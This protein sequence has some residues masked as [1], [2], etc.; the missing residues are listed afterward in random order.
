MNITIITPTI[1]SPYLKTLLESIN[2]QHKLNDLFFINHFIVIDNSPINQLKTNSILNSVS[3]KSGVKRYI[4]QIPFSS[5]ENDYKGHKIY[6]AIPQFVNDEYTIFLDDDNFLE[7]NHIYNFV[8]ILLKK[9]YDWLYSLRNIVNSKNEFICNDFCESLGY[10]HHVFYQNNTFLIDTNCYCIKTSILKKICHIW[11]RK[12]HYN[13]E[14]PDRIFG[15]LLMNEYVNYICTQEHTLSYRVREDNS[16]VNKNLFLQGNKIM[17]EKF[18]NE[19]IF[20]LQPIYIAHFDEKHTNDIIQRIYEIVKKKDVPNISFKQWQLNLLDS[21]GTK[22]YFLNA[23]DSK[24]IPSNS[25]CLIHMCHKENLPKNIFLR[26]DIYKILYT[27]ESPNIRHQEQWDL[28]FFEK[29]FDII[30]TYWESIFEK[31]NYNTIYHPFV[32]RLTNKEYDLKYINDDISQKMKSACI[33]LENRDFSQT[34]KI[35]DVELHACD[36]LRKNVVKNISNVM[37][38][39]CYGKSWENWVFNENNKNQNKNVIYQETESRHLDKDKTID[40]Y[41]KHYFSIILE[42][43]DAEG[44]V[45]EKIFD[46]W[47]VSSIPIYYGNFNDK[48]KKYIGEDIPIDDMMIDLKK[49]GIENIGKYLDEI[50]LDEIEKIQENIKKYKKEV[51]EKVGIEKYNEKIIEVIDFL[52]KNI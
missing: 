19:N 20:S 4:F 42:N 27:I 44:Y 15:N 31:R 6:S 30:I 37:K 1:G 18:G 11:N 45:S 41:N 33:L 26:N 48:L 47:M 38:V 5:G 36:Y 29:N 34:Y 12:A 39:Y 13:N 35:N 2:H 10:L 28:Q 43:C 24:Y 49:I 25:I 40:Y 3:E 32:H 16:G 22:A 9:K 7:K 14:D 23:Y 46:A 51:F 21:L 50:Y 17:V 52:K 8:N